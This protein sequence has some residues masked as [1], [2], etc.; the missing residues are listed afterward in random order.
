MQ[1]LNETTVELQERRLI[2]KLYIDQSVRVQLDQGETSTMKVLRRVKQGC[3]LSLILFN[4]YSEY[5]RNEVLE[6]SKQEDK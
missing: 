3:R 2:S 6:T 5:L 4:F 1:I